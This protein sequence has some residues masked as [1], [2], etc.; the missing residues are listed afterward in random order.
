MT[1]VHRR[2][3]HFECSLLAVS[4]VDIVRVVGSRRPGV[5]NGGRNHPD[6]RDGE[7]R[8]EDSGGVVAN[9]EGDEGVESQG[10]PVRSPSFAVLDNST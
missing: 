3:P 1:P 10:A 9:G 6:E 2:E 7:E 5:A 8:A 4:W